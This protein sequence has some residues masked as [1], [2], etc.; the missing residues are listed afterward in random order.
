MCLYVETVPDHK[1]TDI[2][3]KKCYKH[4]KCCYDFKEYVTPFRRASIGDTGILSTPDRPYRTIYSGTVH[5]NHIHAYHTKPDIN[6][7]NNEAIRTA[8]AINIK[9]YGVYDLVCKLL[10]IP[11]LD[12]TRNI[13]KK[14]NK[15]VL[16][17]EKHYFFD[18]K[19]IKYI[20]N[21]NTMLNGKIN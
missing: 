17:D 7:L 12:K 8:Y 9:A 3:I 16:V 4:I 18:K 11:S 5:G 13:R 20:C 19:Q 14:L 1:S 15:L 21:L 6:L 10:Y 2:I